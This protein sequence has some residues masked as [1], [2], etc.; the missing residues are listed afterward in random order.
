[1]TFHRIVAGF[2][3]Q[4][5]DPAGDGTG[6]PGYSVVEAPPQRPQVHEGHRG[7]GQDRRRAGRHVG[8]AVLRR[9]R[10][11]RRALPP[12][13]ALLGK[14][15]EGLDVVDKIGGVQA[16]PDTGSPRPRSRSIASKTA[17][18]GRKRAT[19]RQRQRAL[20]LEQRALALRA[21]AVVAEPAAVPGSTRWQ[22]T[23]IGI[24][25]RAQAV[26]TARAA[27]GLPARAA[28]SP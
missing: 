17:S 16:D 8:L 6:G 26:P 23:T 11:G 28:S 27:F 3:I 12:D 14:V 7:D 24:G 2:V 22:G 10:R 4:G 9:H 15:T 20:E 19:A 13:Y 18:H 5:G 1:M 25:L 21:A